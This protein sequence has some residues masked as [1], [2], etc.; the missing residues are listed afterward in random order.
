[1]TAATVVPEKTD[2]ADNLG[3]ASAD[4]RDVKR[5]TM[6]LAL[7]V[8]GPSFRRK[9]R[10]EDVIDD[11][12]R[13]DPAM[14][15]LSKDLLDRSAVSELIGEK[16]KLNRALD[17]KSVPCR[18]L[19]GGMRLIPLAL[20]EDVDKMV[21]GFVERRQVLVDK[22]LI[23]YE[24]HKQEAEKRLGRHFD[25]SDYP[26]W[27]QMQRAFTVEKRWLTFNVPAALKSLNRSMYERELERS[28]VEWAEASQD[29]K[30]ALREGLAGIVTNFVDKL[31]V[32]EGGRKKTFRDATMSKLTDWLATFEARNLTGDVEL[33]DL[34]RQAR[35]ALKGVEPEQL[36]KQDVQ[37]DRVRESF[38]EIKAKLDGLLVARPK[39]KFADEE[40]V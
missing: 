5:A 18:M 23:A 15:H 10:P 14:L 27:G 9:M 36:R 28:K 24:G 16:D 32:D 12:D 35:E 30:A 2:D 7:H 1:M 31:G 29:I 37:R 22:L 39:R 25:P 38:E 3:T 26:T 21:D 6:V 13:V 17:A 33:A 8:S 4:P 19:R 20:V 34:A 40:D 11:G